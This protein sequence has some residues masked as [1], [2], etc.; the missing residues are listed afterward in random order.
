MG[1]DT[2][3]NTSCTAA[4]AMPNMASMERWHNRVGG[5]ELEAMLLASMAFVW[6]AGLPKLLQISVKEQGS[7]RHKSMVDMRGSLKDSFQDLR[8]EAGIKYCREA[9]S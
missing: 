9:S 4:P 6:Y 7:A 8:K 1:I 3:V 2:L 5:N